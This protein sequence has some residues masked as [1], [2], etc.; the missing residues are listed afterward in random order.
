MHLVALLRQL[1]VRQLPEGGLV[2]Q[3]PADREAPFPPLH[4]GGYV[5]ELAPL[6]ETPGE[7]IVFHGALR[8]ALR[9]IHRLP[10][11]MLDRGRMALVKCPANGLLPEPSGDQLLL[12]DLDARGVDAPG[13]VFAMS[14]R[15]RDFFPALLTPGG[16]PARPVVMKSPRRS[17]PIAALADDEEVIGRIVG[18]IKK[19]GHQEMDD[20]VESLLER[21]AAA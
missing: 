9:D 14:K 18:V 10:A 13:G 21:R 8:F 19:F 6:A 5:L 4:N 17:Q 12:V 15:G 1:K 3:D 20:L 16:E 2:P 11:H 7:C